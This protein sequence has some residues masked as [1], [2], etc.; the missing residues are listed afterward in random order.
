MKASKTQLD[1]VGDPRDM[2]DHFAVRDRQSGGDDVRGL[3]NSG[4]ACGTGLAENLPNVDALVTNPVP[5]FVQNFA[6]MSITVL[7]LLPRY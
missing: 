3:V 1:S 5:Q 7:L 4:L 6:L 2:A